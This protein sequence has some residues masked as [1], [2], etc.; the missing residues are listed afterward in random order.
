MIPRTIDVAFAGAEPDGTRVYAPP[1]QA[2]ALLCA[3]GLDWLIV[4]RPRETLHGLVLV[5]VAGICTFLV[6]DAVKR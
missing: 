4:N 2:L 3:R 6:R 5:L 1:T